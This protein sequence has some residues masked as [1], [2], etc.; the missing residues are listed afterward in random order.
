L[1]SNAQKIVE[2]GLVKWYTVE[3]ADSLNTKTPRPWLIDVYTGWC[4][5][6]VRMMQ[7]TFSNA[8]I[9]K[10]INDNFYPV[11]FDAE[12]HDTIRFR[13]KK[14]FNQN[15]DPK[16]THQLSQYF[17]GGR[18]SYPTIVYIDR[19]GQINP[20]PGYMTP[21]Q[22]EPILIFFAEDVNSTANFDDFERYF[23]TKYPDSYTDELKQIPDSLKPKTN[24]EVKWLTL[25]AASEM[26]KTAKKPI[27]ITFYTDW[28]LS[29]KVYDDVVF[30]NP[31][32]SKILNENYYPVKFNAASTDT[33]NF[34]GTKLVGTGIG[35]PHQVTSG[36]LRGNYKMPADVYLNDKGE[37][38]NIVNGMLMPKQ[39][40]SILTYLS[41]DIYLKT[42]Y[43]DF[44]KTFKGKVKN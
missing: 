42:K 13:G 22:I 39:L 43:P 15:P 27:F 41:G 9:A 5:W 19:K 11:R 10:Y 14:Y 26:E 24:G 37:L 3:Q 44:L 16:S 32:I 34:F 28:C 38:L 20:V 36:I 30:K 29:C 7:T 12:S 25:T 40:E 18:M 1:F 17:L 33:V 21:K 2:P 23:E 8:G 31:E 35:N 6:C 4:G